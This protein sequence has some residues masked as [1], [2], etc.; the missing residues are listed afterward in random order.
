MKRRKDGR[1]QKS[2]TI[3][4]QRLYFYSNESTARQA[5]L[6]IMRQMLEYTQKE[7]RG[8]LFSEVSEEWE[9]HHTPTIS[10]TTAKRYSIFVK[11]LNVYFGDMYIKE[12]SP[13]LVNMYLHKLELEQY[14]GKTIKDALSVLRLISKYANIQNYMSQDFTAY[15]SPPK[16]KP[17]EK[18]EALTDA[19]IATVKNSIDKPFGFFAYFLLYTGCR[20]G[21]ALALTWEDID[22]EN[23]VIHIN[24]SLYFEGVKPKLKEPK[25]TA[26]KRDIILLTPLA[27]KLT[28]PTKKNEPIFKG[29]HG[30]YMNQSEYQRAWEQYTT[31][32][33]LTITAHQIRHT[34]ATLLFEADI[35]VKDAQTLMGHSDIVTTQNIYTHIRQSRLQNTADKLNSYLTSI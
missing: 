10:P 5:E 17:S 34:F 30:G 31:I 1:W 9:E 28:I 4:G 6:D 22:I 18:R 25:T 13:K 3:S 12:I 24:K 8:K 32:A 11:Q 16:G 33:N 15:V 35:N 27:E 19:E 2:V 20:K 14:S 26:G 21:E 29:M 7:E 23:K